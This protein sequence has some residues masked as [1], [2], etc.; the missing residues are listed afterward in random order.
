GDRA[1]R[2]ILDLY[3]EAFA[4]VPPNERAI[5]EPR[6]R[7]EHAQILAV[8]DI[9]RFA[10]LG[11]IPSMQASHAVG[12]L[13]FAPRRL[14]ENRL[15]GAYAWRSLRDTGV[16]IPG[17]WDAPVEQGDPRIEFYAMTAR[18][19]LDGFQGEN[20]HPEQALTRMEAL[21][22]LTLWPAF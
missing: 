20:W 5:A 4:E 13:H 12:D 10:A 1:N 21:K 22:S 3:A 11:V 8:E 19:D 16:I 14:G 18:R 9:P 15:A 7:I 2:F 6:W 17:G